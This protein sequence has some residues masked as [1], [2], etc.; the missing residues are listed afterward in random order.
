MTLCQNGN[1]ANRNVAGQRPLEGKLAIV[2]GSSRGLGAAFAR[3]LASKGSSLVI[4][5]ISESS[6]AGATALATSLSNE[7]SIK[8]ITAQADLSTTDGPSQ[9]VTVAKQHFTNPQTNTFQIDIIINNAG[10]VLP[11]ALG[12]VTL[13]N[14]DRQYHVN[15][16]GP[17]LLVQAALPNLPT[18]RSGR[19]NREFTS[20]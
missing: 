3:Q 8:A 20:Y 11:E 2:T 1:S 19:M 17:M 6:T 7:Y 15:V 16:R 9:I 4:N 13:E 14:F 18:D 5:Y 10:I 12:S